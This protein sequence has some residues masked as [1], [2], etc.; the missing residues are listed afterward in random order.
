MEYVAGP[1]N[2]E[3][4]LNKLEE[5][6]WFLREVLTHASSEPRY[7]VTAVKNIATDQEE[8]DIQKE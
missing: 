1:A 2:L 7:T 6:G 8:G 5:E 3:L 4:L